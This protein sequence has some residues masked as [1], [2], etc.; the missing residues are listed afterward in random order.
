MEEGI[1]R[2]KEIEMFDHDPF[3]IPHHG[4]LFTECIHTL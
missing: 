3:A 4:E 2:K 1:Q